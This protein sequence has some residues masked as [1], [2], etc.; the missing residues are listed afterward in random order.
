MGFFRAATALRLSTADGVLQAVMLGVGE[1]YLGALAVELG[2][3]PLALAVLVTVPLAAG[4]LAQTLT[5]PLAVA[6]GGRKRLVVL[7]AAVQGLSHVAFVAIATWRVDDLAPLL[8][9]KTVFAIG[10]QVGIPAW[11]AWMATLAKGRVRER[12]FARRGAVSQLGLFGAVTGAGAL[13][14]RAGPAHA[15]LDAYA[16]L[17]VV[18]RVARLLSAVALAFQHDPGAPSPLGTD[19]HLAPLGERFRLALRASEWRVAVYV[20]ALL[21]GAQ[22]AVPFLT[23]FMLQELELTYAEYTGLL[24][25]G[26]LVKAGAFPVAHHVAQ[27]YGLTAVLRVSGAGVA[28]APLVWALSPPIEALIAI[29]VVGGVAWA[30]FEYASFQLLLSSAPAA[31]RMEFLSLA[32]SLAGLSQLLGAVAAGLAMDVLGAS[33]EAVFVTSSVMRALPLVVLL[34]LRGRR[35]VTGPLPPLFMRLVSVR[36]MGGALRQ[37][38]VSNAP[39]AP[40]AGARFE[41]DALALDSRH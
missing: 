2:H 35:L 25:V 1:T 14:Y 34:P 36:P 24:G 37:P 41:D 10:G 21:L 29:E 5:V 39:P 40:G 19:R 26:L 32:G 18:G 22:V 28:V 11:N 15:V 31:C 13:L 17:F 16:A 9:A 6:L 30:G 27:R 38:I 8:A 12:Y 33:Y 3:G 7:A 20:A 23:P 4:A